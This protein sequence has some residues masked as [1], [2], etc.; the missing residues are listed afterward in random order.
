ME[1]VAQT[2]V[3]MLERRAELTPERLVYRFLED[4]E[5]E[6][7]QVL[8]YGEL[9]R[10]ARAIASAMEQTGVEGPAVLLYPPGLDFLAAFFRMPVRR[11]TGNSG[12]SARTAYGR[13]LARHSGG[14]G[15]RRDLD[16]GAGA[17]APGRGHRR[18]RASVLT[19]R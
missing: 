14:F 4:D 6:P 11:S 8:T 15:R 9:D 16:D 12:L 10:H 13:A 7:H 19:H 5:T 1:M 17:F 2:L 3:G 18:R